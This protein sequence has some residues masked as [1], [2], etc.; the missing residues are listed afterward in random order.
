[1][2]V[3]TAPPLALLKLGGALITDK[4]GREAV[5]FDVLARL[6]AELSAWPPAHAGGLII[7]HG[8]G[9]FAH[10]AVQETG[11]L[12]RPLD[13]LAHARVA[14]AAARLSAHVMD[15][16]V[17]AGLPA[18]AV[19]G[20]LLADCRAG[21]IHAVRAELLLPLLRAGLVPVTWGDAA[22]DDAGDGM[23]A[24]TELLLGAIARDLGAARL[25]AATDVDGVFS[26]DPVAH[27]DQP[28]IARITPGSLAG[29]ALGGARPGAVDVTGGMAS[30]VDNLLALAM[31]LPALEIRIVSG[32]RA[33]AVVAALAGED[34]AG[35]T[36][37]SAH[38]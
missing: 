1:M 30:K 38:A 9:S 36:V 2:T 21:G 19:P 34:E 35:G 11:F 5:R 18:V 8:S 4:S 26:L 37:V 22:L 33:G 6:A 32:L 10:V 17:T 13:R 12:E 27:P 7:A 28:P 16:L 3:G 15:A 25:V 31:A 24:S 14:A 23:I 20:G 29:L